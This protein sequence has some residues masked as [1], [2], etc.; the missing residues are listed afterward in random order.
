V[1]RLLQST[2]RFLRP[3]RRLVRGVLFNPRGA[4]IGE[5]SYI[6]R[7]YTL[8][9]PEFLSIGRDTRIHSNAYITPLKEYAG[10]RYT[11]EIKI[12]ND[13]YI[14]RYSYIVA[15]GSIEIKDGCVLSEYVYITDNSH[16]LHPARG[17]IMRQ[18]LES[19]GP[20]RIGHNCFIGLRAS[21][22]AGVTLGAHCVVGANSVVTRSFPPYS[23]VAGCP[24]KLVKIFS[25]ETGDWVRAQPQ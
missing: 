7:P 15:I 21:I 11:P 24:A 10:L 22:M 18:P 19:K 8:L 2:R 20:V 25:P 13:V 5:G 1:N 9:F 6:K 23:M 16:G 12:G 4:R 17:P 3:V 14:G